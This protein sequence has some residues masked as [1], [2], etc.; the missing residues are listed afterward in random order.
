M[1]RRARG[2]KY[3]SVKR[4]RNQKWL[5]DRVEIRTI[6]CRPQWHLFKEYV[7]SLNVGTC[8]SRK[9]LFRAIFFPEDAADTMRGHESTVDH[10]R[11]YCTHLGYLEHVSNGLYRKRFDIPLNATCKLIETFAYNARQWRKWFIPKAERRKA[12]E[13]RC[14]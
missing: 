12:L 9:D 10:Y 14:K 2:A 7:N 3:I 5:W 1:R 11:L 8:F 6:D 4:Y 13:E